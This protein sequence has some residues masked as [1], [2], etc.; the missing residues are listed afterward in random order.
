MRYRDSRRW[1]LR[2]LHARDGA[3]GEWVRVL[4]AGT[5]ALQHAITSDERRLVFRAA[6]G[7]EIR[8]HTTAHALR[9]ARVGFRCTGDVR[10]VVVQMWSAACAGGVEA[11]LAEGGECT[12]DATQGTQSTQR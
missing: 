6:D 9:G 12:D 2:T 5:V 8:L 3:T 7:F 10:Y 11:V 4:D 1:A